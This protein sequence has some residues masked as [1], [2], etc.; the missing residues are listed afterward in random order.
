MNKL[1][2]LGLMLPFLAGCFPLYIA[3]CI[4]GI[5]QTYKEYNNQVTCH[6]AACGFG[7]T[8]CTVY[9]PIDNEQV[10]ISEQYGV[11]NICSTITHPCTVYLFERTQCY[12]CQNTFTDS[13]SHTW[14]DKPYD[15][16]VTK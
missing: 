14:K 16:P 10:P 11:V 15:E 5:G 4:A 7:E 9:D 3:G 12:T 1:V 13:D 8:M 2:L 6:L